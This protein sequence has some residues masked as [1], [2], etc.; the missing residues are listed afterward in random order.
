MQP[1]RNHAQQLGAKDYWAR[2]GKAADY[3]VMYIPGEHFLSAAL[4]QDEGLW[5]WAF[6]RRVLL[7]TPTNLVAIA[8]T[9]AAVWRQEKMAD[10]ARKIGQL[11]KE[12][13]ERL[14]VAAGRLGKMGAASI[15]W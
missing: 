11:G 13:Y 15:A 10:E 3:V 7:A 4:E 12:I 5:E 1:I 14:A 6:Q 2:F 8:R 9:V